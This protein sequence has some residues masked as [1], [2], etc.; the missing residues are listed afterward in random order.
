[1]ACNSTWKRSY[2]CSMLCFKV[3]TTENP[4]CHST[5][6]ADWHSWQ[7]PSLRWTSWPEAV[8]HGNESKGEVWVLWWKNGGICWWIVPC[9]SWWRDLQADHTQQ[10]MWAVSP[11]AKVLCMQV[12]QTKSS[13]TACKTQVGKTS[14][15]CSQNNK[16]CQ[17][18]ISEE[19]W[20]Q[21][22]YGEPQDRTQK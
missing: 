22:A 20:M 3:T 5:E 15:Q 21:K 4:Q 18:Q 10:F 11:W 12:I 2:H 9:C 14:S 13:C 19:P 16:S 8:G 7:P 6:E 17:L 1:M